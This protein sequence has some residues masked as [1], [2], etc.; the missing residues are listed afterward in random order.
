MVRNYFLEHLWMLQQKPKICRLCTI[1]RKASCKELEDLTFQFSFLSQSQ[2]NVMR[3]ADRDIYS[4]NLSSDT[5]CL[6]ALYYEVI[7]FFHLYLSRR[8]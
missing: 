2:E 3:F 8:D 1:F 7:F 6:F 4:V 5:G